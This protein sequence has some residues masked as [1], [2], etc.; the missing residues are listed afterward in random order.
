M[1]GHPNAVRGWNTGWLTGVALGLSLAASACAPPRLVDVDGAPI[2][3]PMMVAA[4]SDGWVA[5][6]TVASPPRA[7]LELRAETSAP[8]GPPWDLTQLALLLADGTSLAPARLS[9]EEP[10]CCPAAAAAPCGDMEEQAEAEDPPAGRHCVH[11]ARAEFVLSRIPA[12]Q[13][14]TWLRLGGGAE[15]LRWRR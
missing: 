8:E 11:V 3:A 6:D 14:S 1:A 4:V 5:V 2:D 9:C 15:L 7:V 12:R 13:D 10:R